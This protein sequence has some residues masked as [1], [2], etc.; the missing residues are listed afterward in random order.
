MR[1]CYNTPEG[2]YDTAKRRGMDLVTVTDHDRISGALAIADRPDVLV[3]CEVTAEFADADL[4]VVR[5]GPSAL[6][7]LGASTSALWASADR[8]R[9]VGVGLTAYQNPSHFHHAAPAVSQIAMFATEV[10]KPT[11]HQSLRDT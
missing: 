2:V 4:C 3:G 10:T 9:L 11:F 1:E 8:P 6:M 5:F 7:G